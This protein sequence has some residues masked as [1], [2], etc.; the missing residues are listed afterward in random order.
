MRHN[1]HSQRDCFNRGC[2]IAVAGSK[3]AGIKS[4]ERDA[5]GGTT[6]AIT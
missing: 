1:Q 4:K 6:N 2:F 5:S 3:T